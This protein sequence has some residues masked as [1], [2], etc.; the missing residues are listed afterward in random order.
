VV[1][2]F[3]AHYYSPV[4]GSRLY[5]KPVKPEGHSIGMEIGSAEHLSENWLGIRLPNA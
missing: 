4:I 5:Q 3:S 1:V 2:A